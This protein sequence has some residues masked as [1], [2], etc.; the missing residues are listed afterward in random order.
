L[1]TLDREEVDLEDH[2]TGLVEEESVDRIVV[3]YPDPLRTDENERTRQVDGFIENVVDP[4]PVPHVTVSERYTTKQAD[5][6]REH[7]GDLSENP[8]D[9]EAAALILDHYLGTERKHD[10][11]SPEEEP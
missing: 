5:E 1:T 6:L 7:R 10:F 2:L 4:L 9:A 3:G 8:P 11:P